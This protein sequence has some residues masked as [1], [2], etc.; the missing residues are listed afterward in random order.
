MYFVDEI[1]SSAGHKYFGCEYGT[2]KNL[3][4][5]GNKLEVA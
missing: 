2:Y 1:S 5:C 3:N 4:N